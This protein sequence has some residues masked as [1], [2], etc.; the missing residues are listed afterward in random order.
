MP[1]RENVDSLTGWRGRKAARRGVGRKLYVGCRSVG[2]NDY[3]RKSTDIER[4]L[5]I[6]RG[7]GRY[8]MRLVDAVDRVSFSYGSQRPGAPEARRYALVV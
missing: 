5:R 4:L 8:V 1:R 6:V 3:L 7:I 2:G